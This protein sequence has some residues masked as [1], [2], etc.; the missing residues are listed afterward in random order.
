M[1]NLKNELTE[2]QLKCEQLDT[3]NKQIEKEKNDVLE[4]Y[5]MSWG[6]HNAKQKIKYTDKLIRDIDSINQ[7]I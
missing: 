6:H 4:T 3:E 2:Y 5:G 1:Y 7:V